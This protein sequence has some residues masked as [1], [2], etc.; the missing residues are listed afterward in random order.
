MIVLGCATQNTANIQS[1]NIQN[2]TVQLS[3]F[4]LSKPSYDLENG[5]MS[6]KPVWTCQGQGYHHAEFWISRLK[7]VWKSIYTSVFV[8]AANTSITSPYYH[9]KHYA[10]CRIMKCKSYKVWTLL[11]MKFWKQNKSQ[12]QCSINSAALSSLKVT[13]TGWKCKA[14]WYALVMQILQDLI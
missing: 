3:Y 4:F 8:Q 9:L 1:A 7:N 6:Q 10:H 11:D 5:S 12:G 2:W 14:Q 13:K